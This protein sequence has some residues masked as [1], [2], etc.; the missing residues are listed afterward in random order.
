M[1]QSL[2]NIL[3]MLDVNEA[4]PA[5]KKFTSCIE[6]RYIKFAINSRKGL[7]TSIYDGASLCNILRAQDSFLQT[8]D[9]K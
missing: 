2:P 3:R 8:T 1:Y 6:S 9:I 4:V 5:D 7:L